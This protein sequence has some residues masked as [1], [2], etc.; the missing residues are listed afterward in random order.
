MLRGAGDDRELRRDRRNGGDDVI[1][2]SD[3][4]DT[5]NAFGGDDLVCALGGN[6][7]IRAGL[8]DDHLDGGEG[9][10]RIAADVVGDLSQGSTSQ[11]GTT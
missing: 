4:A 10:D 2:G 5:I 8:G 7:L 6:D 1:V 11:P 9:N 3:G